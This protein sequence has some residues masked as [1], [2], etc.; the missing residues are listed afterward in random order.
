LL[1]PGFPDALDARWRPCDGNGAKLSAP[2]TIERLEPELSGTRFATRGQF[3]DRVESTNDTLREL[4]RKGAP[5]GTFVVAAEQSGGRGRRGGTWVSPAGLGLFMS[6]LFRPPPG[7]PTRWTLGTAVA[8]CDACRSL[9]AIT[10]SIKWPNDLTIGSDKV[11]G[12]LVETR[13]AGPAVDELI[14]GVGIN[15]HHDNDEIA[16][17]GAPAVTS[18]RRAVPSGILGGRTKL[19]GE[20]LRRFDEIATAIEEGDWPSVATAWL[21]RAPRANAAPV[22]ITAPDGTRW[23]GISAGLADDGALLVRDTNDRL[24]TIRQIDSVRFTEG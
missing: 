15:V 14:V 24:H 22:S 10:T 17:I 20:F 5:P 18:L 1:E 13:T 3:L 16:A 4:A 21:D 9:G 19:A 8:A 6:V 7:P 23:S 12:I 2:S 11:G